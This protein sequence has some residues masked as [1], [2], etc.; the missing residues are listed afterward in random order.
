MKTSLWCALHIDPPAFRKASGVGDEPMLLYML[1][2]GNLYYIPDCMSVYR[3]CSTGSW[4]YKNK[5][6]PQRKAI[7][8]K[9][10]YEMMCLF[11][12]YTD[13]KYDCNLALYRGRMYLYNKDFRALL[14]RENKPYLRQLTFSK[15]VFVVLGACF[16][17]LG[18]YIK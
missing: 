14:S 10:Q 6:D 11:D 1:A 5:V 3:I 15:R 17:F 16:P 18:R 7:H 13:H 2:H 9:K 12:E 8:A 4:S